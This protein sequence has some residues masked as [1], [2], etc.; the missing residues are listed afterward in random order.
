MVCNKGSGHCKRLWECCR[1]VTRFAI[2]EA[3]LAMKEV[4]VAVREKSVVVRW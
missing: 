2:R 3:R 4:G 1:N